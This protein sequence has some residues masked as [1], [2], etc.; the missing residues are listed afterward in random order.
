[1]ATGYRPEIIQRAFVDFIGSRLHPFWSLTRPKLRLIA[2]HALNDDLVAVQFEGNHAFKRQALDSDGGWHGGQ[3]INLTAVIDAIYHQRHY[4]LV[5]LPNQSL[6]LQS[7]IDNSESSENKQLQ[8]NIITIAI[9]PQ[10]L[11]SNYLTQQAPLGTI[12]DS[13]LPSGDFTL[14]Q[15]KLDAQ[16]ANR[17]LLA[18]S[19]LLFIAG[20]SGITPMLG[21]ITQALS[22]GH[23]VTLL[24]YSRMPLAETPFLKHWQQLKDSYPNFTYHFI[25]TEDPDSYLASTRHL[26][27]ESLLALNLPLVDTQIFVCGSQALLAGLYDAVQAITSLDMDSLKDKRSLHDNL[28]FERFGSLS[29]ELAING[30][31]HNT[32][33]EKDDIATQTVYLR[34]RQRQF[35]TNTTLLIG[36]E[37]AGITL[38]YGCRQGICQLCRCNKASGVVKN[39][40]TGKISSDGYESIQTCINIAMTDVVL[41]I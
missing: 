20:G 38:S 15:A 14:A 9:K 35:N 16:S 41:D 4:S 37:Q 40:E 33:N 13:S 1:M 19:S 26:S 24:Y 21:L 31:S 10:G 11:V 34:G 12:F 8:S 2:R 7:D 22:Q 30:N 28:I 17:L 18:P 3:H 6:S 39:I 23:T 25:N 32:D 29:H 36:A 27:A 5:G